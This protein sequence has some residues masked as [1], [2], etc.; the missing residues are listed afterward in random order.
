MEEDQ[1]QEVKSFLRQ[2]QRPDEEHVLEVLLEHEVDLT[3]LMHFEDSDFAEIGLNNLVRLAD[4][5]AFPPPTRLHLF[6][7]RCRPSIVTDRGAG[8][9]AE[10]ESCGRGREGSSGTSLTLNC[11][12]QRRGYG[13]R[14][15]RR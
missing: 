1:I 13:P 4:S 8:Y 2:L 7:G 11:G 9:E 6:Y 14:L 15:C 10:V 12:N 5:P 3:A